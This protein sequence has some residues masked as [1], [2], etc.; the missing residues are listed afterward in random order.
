MHSESKVINKD[1]KSA[2]LTNNS[3]NEKSLKGGRPRNR[4]C[5][6]C[7]KL[8]PKAELIKI[9][10]RKNCN[11]GLYPIAIDWKK[12]IPG[13]S[14]YIYPNKFCLNKFLSSNRR[15]SF[16]RLTSFNKEINQAQLNQ[17]IQD[18]ECNFAIDA[19]S[20]CQSESFNSPIDSPQKVSV[21]ISHHNPREG[22]SF[23]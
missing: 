21:Q 2:N 14:A 13:R 18:L 4:L 6:G 11:E 10:A 15:K 22:G 1:L 8:L 7:N 16:A 19:Y 23:K 20:F 17:I 5:V 12:Q 9:T 3:K